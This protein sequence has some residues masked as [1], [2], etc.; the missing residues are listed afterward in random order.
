[1]FLISEI[2]LHSMLTALLMTLCLETL[3]MVLQRVK[4]VKLYLVLIITNIVTNLTMNYLLYYVSLVNYNKVLILFEIGVVFIEALVF[5][6]VVKDYKK[7]LRISF[8][9]NIISWLGAY[10]IYYFI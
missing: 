9:N 1:M 6:I 7:S 5:N 3:S 4:K 10:L 8:I 2:Y